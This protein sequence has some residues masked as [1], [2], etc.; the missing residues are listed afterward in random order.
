MTLST[1]LYHPEDSGLQQY[2]TRSTTTR[3]CVVGTRSYTG[4]RSKSRMSK[5]S[6]LTAVV[7]DGSHQE[8]QRV[9]GFGHDRI[10]LSLTRTYKHEGRC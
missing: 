6:T 7:L 1:L 3:A 5:A 2:Q 4:H 8:N 10:G 9:P